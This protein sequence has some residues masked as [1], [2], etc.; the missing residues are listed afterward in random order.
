[1]NVDS[2]AVPLYATW[3]EALQSLSLAS[4]TEVR[5]RLQYVFPLI[6]QGH[7]EKRYM[8][9][10]MEIFFYMFEDYYC[11]PCQ[12]IL[13]GACGWPW[14]FQTLSCHCPPQDPKIWLILLYPKVCCSNLD[15]VLMLQS[16]WRDELTSNIFIDNTSGYIAEYC[17]FVAISASED[18]TDLHN[19]KSDLT[20]KVIRCVQLIFYYSLLELFWKEIHAFKRISYVINGQKSP[21]IMNIVYLPSWS[22]ETKVGKRSSP[23]AAKQSGFSYSSTTASAGGTA[24]ELWITKPPMCH[25]PE[26]INHR[27]CTKAEQMP[28][29]IRLLSKDQEV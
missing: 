9:I 15:K 13:W 3:A 20:V 2:T 24:I 7:E 29:M 18:T 17:T 6:H 21:R 12:S 23:R 19:L 8:F 22:S 10:Y 1:M 26:E 27:R 28:R 16:K 5:L 25:R 4:F 11:I 14:V